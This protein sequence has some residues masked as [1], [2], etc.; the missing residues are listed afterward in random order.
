MED[1]LTIYKAEYLRNHC[2]NLTQILKLGWGDQTELY[3]CFQWRQPV[4]KDD[5]KITSNG[6][7]P[8]NIKS[9]ISQQPL[10]GSYSS[11][12]LKLRWPNNILQ[13]PEMKTS[14]NGRRPQTIKSGISQQPLIAP[15]SN[16]KLMLF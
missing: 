1:D 16:L 15:Y 12:K 10:I 7:Q 2:L 3:R 11:F 13:I 14:S 4:I 5:L 8:Q 9:G 6:R